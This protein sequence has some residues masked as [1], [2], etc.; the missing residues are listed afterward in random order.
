MNKMITEAS[1]SRPR[2][3]V[4]DDGDDLYEIFMQINVLYLR[5]QAYFIDT[6]TVARSA[7]VKTNS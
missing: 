5:A 4:I 2:S 6:A 7:V 1:D 3:I